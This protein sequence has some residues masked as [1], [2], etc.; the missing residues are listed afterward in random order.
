MAVR[1]RRKRDGRLGTDAPFKLRP[2]TTA[3]L[4][5]LAAIE[6][7]V[8]SDPWLR[9]DFRE[10]LASRALAEVAEA[11]QEIVGYVIARAASDEGEILNLA[12]APAHQRRGVGRALARHA[13]ASL[14]ARGA[15]SVYLEVR[16]SNVAARALYEG[17]GF[18]PVA[19]RANYYRHPVEAALILRAANSAGPRDA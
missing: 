12:V 19:R 10:C 4:D 6:R 3:D 16:E 18:E 7:A 13:L 5:A 11:G 14:A 1:Q 2:A 8:F 17:L 9:T 15:R